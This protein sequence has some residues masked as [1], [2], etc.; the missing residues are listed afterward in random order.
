MRVFRANTL[1]ELDPFAEAWDRLAGGM[2]FRSWTWLSTW[3]RH[4]GDDRG[5]RRQL[6]V[7][8]VTDHQDRLVGVA[9]WYI[10]HSGAWGGV[11]RFL[12]TGEV[13]SEYLSVLCLPGF[14]GEVA[15]SLADWLVAHVS[16]DSESDA[17]TDASWNGW[18]LLELMDVDRNDPVVGRLSERLADGGS[19][20]HRREGVSCW[21]A[22]LPTTVDEYLAN[23]SKHA[24]NRFRRVRREILDS[25]LAT[26]RTAR[27]TTDL[28]DGF[29][30]FIDLHQLRRRA[31]GQP[32]C[33][34]S[35]RYNAFHREAARR[36]FMAGHAQL[37]VLH[38]DGRPI[39][40]EYQLCGDGV[41]HAYQ[42]G[43]DPARLDLAP[44]RVCQI[45]ILC[46]AIE[47]G[48]RA[49]DMLR[50]DEPYKMHWRPRRVATLETRVIAPRTGARL[51]YAAWRAG[52]DT[53][54]WLK[55][56]LK[57]IRH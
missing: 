37:H 12:G 47:N 29:E 28:S 56:G 30:T 2:P 3:W 44:G 50:G 35:P 24:R 16:G 7:L 31:L 36:M 19:S 22:E 23:L 39:A 51:C 49:Y 13:C 55:K 14:E 43:I 10:C 53:K 32:G 48:Y 45:A 25:G 41:V 18:G 52:A 33:F 15:Q 57:Q 21:R 46:W 4:Y 8:C 17:A 11:L 20:I 6:C 5:D 9:P 34:T 38:R 40:A 1:D 26:L 27:N 42:T 54:D